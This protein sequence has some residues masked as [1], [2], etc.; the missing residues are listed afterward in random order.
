MPA[1]RGFALVLAAATLAA[2]G[3]GGGESDATEDRGTATKTEPTTGA[4][5]TAGKTHRGDGFTFTYPESWRQY[6]EDVQKSA[7]KELSSVLLAPPGTHDLSFINVTTYDVGI[8]VTE[9]NVD[10]L[11]DDLTDSVNQ[12]FGEGKIDEGPTRTSVA[13]LPGYEFRLS[14][15]LDGTPAS[16]RL[17]QVFDGNVQYYFYCQWV[18]ADASSIGDGC[19][20]ML[21]SFALD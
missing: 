3:C 2:P 5:A 8:D 15:V 6:E 17:V 7:G 18:G 4:A 20:Q 11:E 21:D 16:V 10:E 12:I 9:G 13:G 19:A 14:A 1:P